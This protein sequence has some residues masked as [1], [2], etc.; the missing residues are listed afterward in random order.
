MKS[1][2]IVRQIE[3]IRNGSE[4]GKAY[5]AFWLTETGCNPVYLTARIIGRRQ[6]RVKETIKFGGGE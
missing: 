2:R 1:S 6:P 5:A 3:T 4:N